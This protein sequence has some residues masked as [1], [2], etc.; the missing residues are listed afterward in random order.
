MFVEAFI[1]SSPDRLPCPPNSASFRP[2]ETTPG[3]PS[4]RCAVDPTS[5]TLLKGGFPM[6]PF[7]CCNCVPT[8]VNESHTSAFAAGPAHPARAATTAAAA[9][10]PISADRYRMHLELGRPVCLNVTRSTGRSVHPGT[11]MSSTHPTRARPRRPREP[12]SRRPRRQPSA[13]HSRST[14]SNASC[15]RAAVR[16]PAAEFVLPAVAD[17]LNR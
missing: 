3:S 11:G 10:A 1:S 14:R 5:L 8:C 2:S 7:L 13:R 4:K 9:V 17:E 15:E 12:G 6:M 16:W